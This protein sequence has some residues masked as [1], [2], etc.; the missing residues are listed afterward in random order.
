MVVFTA[1]EIWKHMPKDKRDN[2]LASVHLLNWPERN[3]AFAQDDLVNENKDIDSQF[4]YII[5]LIP[6]VAKA[7]EEKRNQEII[8]SSFDAQI[9]LLTNKQFYYKYLDGLK[10]DL[11]EIFKVSQV[12]IEKKDDLSGEISLIVL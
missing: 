8:G 7:L 11:P 2:S 3:P 12:I 4:K 9:I 10:E 5:E 6:P 1:E